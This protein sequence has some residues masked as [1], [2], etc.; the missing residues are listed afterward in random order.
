MELGS[1]ERRARL[2]WLL[3]VLTRRLRDTHA[4]DA[5]PLPATVKLCA[6]G[7]QHGHSKCLGSDPSLLQVN[8]HVKGA[9]PL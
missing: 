3:A 4:S 5:R 1:G 7:D 6:G 8:L 9:M 2:G